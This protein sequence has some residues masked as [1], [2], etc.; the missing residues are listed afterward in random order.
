MHLFLPTD[1]STLKS[2]GKTF[3]DKSSF[4]CLLCNSLPPLT[5]S[6]QFGSTSTLL[7]TFSRKRLT[8]FFFS[9]N[10]RQ[11]LDKTRRDF[12]FLC[13]TAEGANTSLEAHSECKVKVPVYAFNPVYLFEPLNIPAK[14]R[15]KVRSNSQLS[16]IA[17]VAAVS[18]P[19][20]GGDRTSKRKS[21]RAKEH[22][23]G[24]QKLGELGRG[25]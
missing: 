14:M 24:E 25:E 7:T 10:S 2:T 12:G 6:S 8:H 11:L 1:S 20:P 21:G 17:C 18:F 16:L 4:E 19:F 15:Q 5:I 23:W 9:S 3:N 13:F 22:V